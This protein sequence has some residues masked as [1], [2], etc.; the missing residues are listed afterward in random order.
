M[1][2]DTGGRRIAHHE[3]NLS[4]ILQKPIAATA[5]PLS[6]GF[7]AEADVESDEDTTEQFGFS[8]APSA[9]YDSAAARAIRSRLGI[10]AVNGDSNGV[11]GEGVNKR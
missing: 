6:H 9:L 7:T 1:S 8:Q 10:R 2:L 11:N 3:P 4:H 5:M